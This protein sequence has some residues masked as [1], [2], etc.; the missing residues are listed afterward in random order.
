[1]FEEVK[2]ALLNGFGGPEEESATV[3]TSPTFIQL[4]NTLPDNVDVVSPFVDRVMSFISGF[5]GADGNHFEIELALREALVNAIVHGNHED[6]QKRVHVQCRITTDGEVSI[7]VEDEGQGFEHDAVADPA[8]LE[9]RLRT[10]GRGINLMRALM[11]EVEF[12]QGGSAVHM[13]KAAKSGGRAQERS[14]ANRT[15]V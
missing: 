8:A 13:R 1:M 7:G 11:D 9:N 5:P 4:R 10:H 2:A 6:P 15:P 14:K 12:E 3:K